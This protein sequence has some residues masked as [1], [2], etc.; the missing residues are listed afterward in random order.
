MSIKRILETIS[1]E[2]IMSL[3]MISIIPIEYLIVTLNANIDWLFIYLA[4]LL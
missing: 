2:N 1:Y 3:H 4:M